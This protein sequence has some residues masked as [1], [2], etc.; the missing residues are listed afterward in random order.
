MNSPTKVAIVVALLAP[1]V[2]VPAARHFKQ[3][4]SET[5]ALASNH[6]GVAAIYDP[7][8][9]N[10]WGN[11]HAPGGPLWVSDNG[12]NKSTLYKRSTGD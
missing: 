8:V 6:P 7:D 5:V 10:A 9:V 1:V 11:S 3:T 4:G 2:A 12:T